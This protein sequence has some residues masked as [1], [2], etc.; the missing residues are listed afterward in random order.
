MCI[1]DRSNPGGYYSSVMEQFK[2]GN[3]CYINSGNIMYL[4]KNALYSCK[5][6]SKNGTQINQNLRQDTTK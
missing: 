5:R 2:K 3:D 6:R 1:R 4:I